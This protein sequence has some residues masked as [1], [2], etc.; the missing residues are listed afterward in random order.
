MTK[1]VLVVDDDVNLCMVAAEDLRERGYRVTVASSPDEVPALLEPDDV[2]VVLTDV[3]MQG[4]CGFDLCTRIVESERDVPVVVMTGSGSTAS[5]VGAIRAGA[6]DYVAKPLEMMELTATL[7][8]AV[9]EHLLRSEARRLRAEIAGPCCEDECMVG[10]SAAM[11]HAVDLVKRVAMTEATVLV[12]GET[13]TG[14]ELVARAIHA[15]SARA[16]GPFVAINCA[17]TPEPLLESELFGHS[18]GAFT[19]AH[20]AREGLFV[21]ATNGTLFLDEVGEMPA[22]MQAKLLRALQERTVRPVGGDTEVA[23]DARIVA[24][25][26]LDLEREVAEKRFRDDLLFRINVVHISVPPLRDRGRDILRLATY[27]L[28]KYQP[29]ARPVVGFSPAVI[30]AFLSYRW[31]GNVRELEN[32]IQRAVALAEFD[33]VTLGDLPESMRAAPR[34][35]SEVMVP[36]SDLITLQELERRYIA[37]VLEATNNNK[38]LAARILGFDR[39]TLYRKLSATATRH[40]RRRKPAIQSA[41]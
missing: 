31:P 6:Y 7:D 41:A 8:R 17:A 19:D 23:F 30:G 40:T 12:T 16:N 15:R 9:S 4:T 38:S 26:N 2:D 37:H 35:A 27:M 5:A 25:T 39:R 20:Q 10:T 1:H 36:A 13:G 32:V 22:S 29:S 33:H 28:R 18:R 11:A 24:A 3:D 14:K 21:K 34:C